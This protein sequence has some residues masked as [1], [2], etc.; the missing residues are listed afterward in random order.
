MPG[1]VHVLDPY[2]GIEQGWDT[3][4]A[5]LHYLEEVVHLESPQTIAAFILEPV[6]GTNGILVLRTATCRASARCVIGTGSC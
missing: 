2:H 3:A 6:P 5:A 1:V 4:E